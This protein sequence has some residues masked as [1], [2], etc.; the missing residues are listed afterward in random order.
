MAT[1][2]RVLF[3][4]DTVLKQEPVQ[5][6]QLP[7]TKQQNIPIGTL[8]V[9]KFYE[10]PANYSDHYKFALEDLQFKGFS[11]W[12]A[13][14][15]HVTIIQEAINPVTTIS[16]IATQQQAKDTVKITVD[17]QSV[18]NQQGFLKLVFNADTII[19]RQPVDSKVLNDQSKQK[20]PAGTELIL[21]T[22][23]PDTNNI[24]KFTIQDSHLKF[25][26]KDVE[27]KGF[28]K[29]WFVFTQHVGIQGLD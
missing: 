20:I 27:F 21:L 29:D 4:Q 15:K 2:N 28:S 19:K 7:S 24:V 9:L 1:L 22:D 23:K 3:I 18:G 6:G 11:N 5:S 16:A 13:F 25:S 10:I 8:F 14:A 26:L 17:R 12:Y